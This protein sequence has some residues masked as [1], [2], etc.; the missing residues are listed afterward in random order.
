MIPLLT[1]RQVDFVLYIAKYCYERLRENKYQ[2]VSVIKNMRS[3]TPL[4]V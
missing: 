4:L 2:Q 1:F 3:L